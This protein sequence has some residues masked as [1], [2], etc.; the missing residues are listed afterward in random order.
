MRVW[1]R[2]E[3]SVKGS[4]LL[5]RV[6]TVSCA[7]VSPVPRRG[8]VCG[9]LWE[10]PNGTVNE[11]TPGRGPD[12]P[13]SPPPAAR[14]PSEQSR[15]PTSRALSVVVRPRRS[16]SDLVSSRAERVSTG[17]ACPNARA[18][19]SLLLRGPKFSC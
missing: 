12:K 13:A 8:P 5:T 10:T 19:F 14:P 1:A 2:C 6:V 15:L 4:Q 7:P 18:V 17:R 3:P 9:K 16:R 11:R